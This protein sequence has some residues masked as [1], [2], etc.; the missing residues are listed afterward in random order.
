MGRSP[1]ALIL[2]NAIEGPGWSQRSSVQ[3]SSVC[4]CLNGSS[5]RHSSITQW[6]V[7]VLLS[8]S[9][10]VS[11]VSGCNLFLQDIKTLWCPHFNL[12]R[13]TRSSLLSSVYESLIFGGILSKTLFG[14][15]LLME[16]VARMLCMS[17]EL[18]LPFGAVGMVSRTFVQFVDGMFLKFGGLV[19]CVVQW[20]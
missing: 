17:V 12:D 3:S 14:L 15:S 10:H 9:G 11:D 1:S 19:Q 13:W 8:Q 6:I 7:G 16:R 20:M 5:D 2:R 4:K 18:L